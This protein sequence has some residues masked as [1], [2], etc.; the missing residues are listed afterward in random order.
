VSH[1]STPP[2]APARDEKWIKDLPKAE[3]HCHLEGC[4][5]RELV[6]RAAKR[7]GVTDPWAQSGNS[8]PSIASLAELLDYL[9]FSCAL[10]DVGDE[11]A[12]I[13]YCASSH[14]TASGAHYLDVIMT[15]LHWQAWEGRIDAMLDAV[16]AGFRQAEQDGLA[17]AGLC[18]SINRQQSAAAA[19]D[20]VDW[21][22]AA[23][24]PRV[25]AVSIDG[26]EQ[27]GSNNER[28]AEAFSLAASNGFR[29][30]AHAGESSG[31]EGVREAIEILG[32]ERIDHGIRAIEDAE[33]VSDLSRLRI[34]LDI[35]PTS[36]QV[37]G[38]TPDPALHPVDRLRAAGVRVS[39]NTD[40]PLVYGC[41]LH[42]EYAATARTFG[43]GK[44]ELI[45]IA[46]TSIDSCFAEE[47]RRQD[48]IRDLDDYVRDSA[49]GAGA[50]GS[51]M[52]R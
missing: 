36:N 50:A 48:L 23:R 27:H 32:A 34:P 24:H 18:L 13:A 37:L 45:S 10:I 31:P 7:R 40:D 46:R 51:A 29:R 30:C 11:L 41:E 5:E 19:R 4:I 52:T 2:P 35:C 6:G 26:N 21:M 16:D 44:D 47:G 28:F 49:D 22:T 14:A 33:L 42:G 1:V 25:V 39:L 15:P 8:T 17:P 20:M 3:V 12:A 43:W 9:D 38:L